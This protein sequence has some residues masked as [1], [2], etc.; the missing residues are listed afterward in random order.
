MTIRRY[1]AQKMQVNSAW[2]SIFQFTV[3]NPPIPQNLSTW[4]LRGK[5]QRT[6]LPN[7][8]LDLIPRMDLGTDTSQLIISLTEL[9]TF[10]LGI[11]RIVFEVLRVSPPPQRP[12]LKFYIEN[13]AGVVDMLTVMPHGR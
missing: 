10:Q 12:I 3:G 8:W 7:N 1:V 4:S 6:N 9:D 13:H 5:C 2:S 11:G